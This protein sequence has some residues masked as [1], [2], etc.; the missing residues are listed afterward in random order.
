MHMYLCMTR[1]AHTFRVVM[2]MHVQSFVL[3]PFKEK[4]NILVWL[5]I[6]FLSD[7]AVDPVVGMILLNFHVAGLL[8]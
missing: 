3:C 8:H 2:H 7:M 5:A 4:F 6:M 1:W